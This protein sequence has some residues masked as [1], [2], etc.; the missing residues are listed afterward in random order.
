MFPLGGDS[1]PFLHSKVVNMLHFQILK[2]YFTFWFFI[3]GSEEF[4]F[5]RLMSNIT[6]YTV[7]VGVMMRITVWEKSIKRKTNVV[8][9]TTIEDS[10]IIY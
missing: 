1:V 4:S 2:G 5:I 3:W 9:E 7:T 10:N 8:D 6:N